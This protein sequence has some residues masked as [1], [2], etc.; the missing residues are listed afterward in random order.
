[1]AW[2]GY[3]AATLTLAVPATLIVRG[4]WGAGAPWWF[5]FV[6]GILNGVVLSS[7]WAKAGWWG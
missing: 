1:M 2:L 6:A 5:F 7:V 3:I 4:V